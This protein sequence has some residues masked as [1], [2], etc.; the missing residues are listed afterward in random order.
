VLLAFAERTRV[1]PEQYRRLVI[2]MDGDV[3][4]TFLADR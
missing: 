4:Q 2:R 1:L 3:A